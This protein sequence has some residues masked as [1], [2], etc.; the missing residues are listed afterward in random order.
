MR[1]N[2][3]ETPKDWRSKLKNGGKI[4]PLIF[5]AVAIAGGVLGYYVGRGAVSDSDA[6]LA[7]IRALGNQHRISTAAPVIA[8]GLTSVAAIAGSTMSVAIVWWIILR[9]E[10]GSKD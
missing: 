1:G 7:L 10:K 2:A 4:S 3:L 5:V 8:V 9:S 6:M